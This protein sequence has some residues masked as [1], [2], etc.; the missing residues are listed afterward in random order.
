MTAES[1]SSIVQNE[2][3]AEKIA[4]FNNYML[5][6]FSD[7]AENMQ[8]QPQVMKSKEEIFALFGSLVPEKMTDETCL[9]PE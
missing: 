1:L 3:D 6:I 9:L 4:R 7:E 5:K 8:I 2:E